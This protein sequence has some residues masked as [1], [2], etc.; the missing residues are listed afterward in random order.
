MGAGATRHDERMAPRRPHRAHPAGDEPH[1]RFPPA[2]ERTSLVRVRWARVER[3]MRTS[4]PLA[5]FSLDLAV[6]TGVVVIAALLSVTVL[7]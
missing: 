4:T 3:A 5:A 2:S 1:P 6:T 7:A